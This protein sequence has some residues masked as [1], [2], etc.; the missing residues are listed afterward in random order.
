MDR[1]RRRFA[2]PIV[3][4]LGLGL[5]FACA[6]PARAEDKPDKTY[7]RALYST[8]LIVVQT[9]KVKEDGKIPLRTGTGALIDIKRRLIVTNYHVVGD[10]ERFVVYFPILN[11]NNQ[12]VLERAVYMKLVVKGGG[13]PGKTIA[14]VPKHDLALIK[15]DQVP[16]GVRALKLS[17]TQ[18]RLDDPVHSIGNPGESDKMWIY[19][20]RKVTKNEVMQYEYKSIKLQ[21]DATI[22]ETDLPPKPGESG[23][24]LV[25]DKGELVGITTGRERGIE[26]GLFVDIS[27]VKEMLESKGFLAKTKPP[28][29]GA[30]K[31]PDKDK[32]KPAPEA[33]DKE[34]KAASKLKLAKRLATD[35]LTA[36][37]IDRCQEIV[38]QYP[39]TKA[40]AEAKELVEKLKSKK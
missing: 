20:H 24:P 32:T 17:A 18:A 10:D 28:G 21:V 3:S 34:E 35:G 22:V 7:K 23:G 13:I 27:H 1:I 39:D 9:G 11:A 4:V 12:V 36:K 26:R 2:I 25:N 37:A 30:T 33:I 14:K 8:V 38:K 19:T 5:L 6:A 15:L 31:P 40:A 29:D 16:Y